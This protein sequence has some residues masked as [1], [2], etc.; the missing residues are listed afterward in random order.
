MAGVVLAQHEVEESV[1]AIRSVLGVV[2]FLIV[3]HI[4]LALAE[5]VFPQT[6]QHSPNLR[7][8]GHANRALLCFHQHQPF[9]YYKQ[10]Q[11][12]NKIKH[13]LTALQ[14]LKIFSYVAVSSTITLSD[15]LIMDKYTFF[16]LVCFTLFNLYNKFI[17]L[18]IIE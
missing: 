2:H 8:L 18:Y 14:I 3:G 16:P 11:L 10:N 7:L 12:P 15:P 6:G 9:Y 5:E 13:W 1:E 17:N 4:L